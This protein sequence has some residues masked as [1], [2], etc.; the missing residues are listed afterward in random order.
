MA[1]G[2]SQPNIGKDIGNAKAHAGRA[3]VEHT[4]CLLRGCSLLI[5]LQCLLQEQMNHIH[6]RPKLLLRER[7]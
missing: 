7:V 5:F 2:M 6:P 3:C 4:G 1:W